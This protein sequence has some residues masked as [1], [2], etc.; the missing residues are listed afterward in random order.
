MVVR[1]FISSFAR[2]TLSFY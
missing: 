1:E 2:D